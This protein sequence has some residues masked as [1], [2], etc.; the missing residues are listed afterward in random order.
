MIARERGWNPAATSV[1]L[2]MADG[3]TNRRALATHSTVLRAKY[4]VDGRT[5]RAWL[6]RPVGRI[7]ALSFLPN[8]AVVALRSGPGAV[9]RPS[10]VRPRAN[11]S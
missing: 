8:D 5:V 1:W 2:V 11:P 9:G 3:R 7:Q 10:R 4:P 6:N